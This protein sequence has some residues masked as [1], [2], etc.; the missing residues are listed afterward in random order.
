MIEFLGI[1]ILAIILLAL[2][3][4]FWAVTVFVVGVLVL[5]GTAQYFD[6]LKQADAAK[7]AKTAA[8]KVHLADCAAL[9]SSE[10]DRVIGEIYGCRRPTAPR[11]EP[12]QD[13]Q[14][15]R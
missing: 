3:V 9:T 15:Q 8:E 6:S 1:C 5:I 12:I 2:A 13:V 4:R 11:G 14:S 10:R 7:V